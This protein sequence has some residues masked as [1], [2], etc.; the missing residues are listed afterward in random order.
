MMRPVVLVV[1]AFL[2]SVSFHC[3]AEESTGL[4][5]RGGRLVTE[6]TLSVLE[7]ENAKTPSPGKSFL[8]SAA[9]PGAG[10]LYQGR[11]IGWVFLAMDA[12]IWTGYF[13][14]HS[15]GKSL[16]DDYRGFADEHYVLSNPNAGNDGERGWLQ[17]WS[18]FRQADSEYAFADS[19]YWQDIEYDSRNSK[20]SYYQEIDVSDTYIYGWDD[21]ADSEFSNEEYWWWDNEGHLQFT[22]ESEHREKYRKLR[23]DADSY[24]K[25]AGRFLGGALLL[26][27]ASAIEALRTARTTGDQQPSSFGLRVDW[28]RPEPTLV[29]SWTRMM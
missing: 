1:F 25:W 5:M 26:R 3:R 18:F 21:W 27:A 8:L 24:K 17:W 7:L 14:T 12:A 2:V 6:D 9:V 22:N 29:L 11:K 13:M 16:E 15:E 4:M 19:I 23:G 10:Q 20:S 28:L